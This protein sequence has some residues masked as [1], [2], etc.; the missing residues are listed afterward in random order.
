MCIEEGTSSNST[1]QDTRRL[2]V[3]ELLPKIKDLSLKAL[4]KECAANG[5]SVRGKAKDARNHLKHKLLREF[6]D[7]SPSFRLRQKRKELGTPYDYL[8]IID[9]EC[10]CKQ[11]D[12]DD[13]YKIDVPP[14]DY[15]II[16][17]PAV[18]MDVKKKEIIAEFRRFVKPKLNPILTAFCTQLTG[19]KQE[20]VDNAEAFPVV[21]EAFQ[22]FLDE[23]GLNKD[24]ISYTIV[25]DGINDIPNFFQF[26]ISTY[27][28][29]FP[30]NFRNFVEVRQI[31]IDTFDLN[32]GLNLE[33]LV[34]MTG[35]EFEGTP[36]R[37]I[38]DARNIVKVVIFLLDKEIGILATHKLVKQ[39][40][41]CMVSPNSKDSY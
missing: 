6:P 25:T 40:F 38:D 26:A 19:I 27:N 29:P 12:A 23:H 14:W 28:L 7:L 31:F 22:Q 3:E 17:F 5:L 16:E 39:K 37:G 20:D 4:R 18:I 32:Y 41:F 1:D 30:H 33:K 35:S 9:F 24:N 8:V 36:H 15:E 34:Q 13:R 21:L 10:T 11:S 2:Y